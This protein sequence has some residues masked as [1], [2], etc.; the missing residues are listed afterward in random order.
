MDGHDGRRN[1]LKKLYVFSMLFVLFTSTLVIYGI[2]GWVVAFGS[3]G[4]RESHGRR[5]IFLVLLACGM[6][7]GYIK[8]DGHEIKIR[9]KRDERKALVMR[10]KQ[11]VL[12]IFVS[13]FVLL[14]A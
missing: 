1:A 2:G 10:F 5:G 8:Y 3:S 11:I 12:I 7:Y 4:F 14:I 9:L 6:F 13:L